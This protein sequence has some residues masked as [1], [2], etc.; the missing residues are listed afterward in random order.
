MKQIFSH[1]IQAYSSHSSLD[2]FYRTFHE[3]IDKRYLV[4]T[5]DLKVEE[6]GISS[7]VHDSINLVK[8]QMH[9]INLECI[10]CFYNNVFLRKTR[11]KPHFSLILFG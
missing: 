1:V 2:E 9:S 10:F 4:Y 8:I 11:P 5:K 3:R 6:N 7:N